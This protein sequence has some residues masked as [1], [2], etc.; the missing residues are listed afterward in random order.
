VKIL[1]VSRGNR[2]LEKAFRAVA[3]VHLATTTDLTDPATSFDFVVLDD[4]TPSVGL[5]AMFW[6][7]MS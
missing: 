1:L 5:H 7:F 6:R 2:L 4:L 3:N